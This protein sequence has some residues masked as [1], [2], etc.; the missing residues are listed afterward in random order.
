MRFASQRFDAVYCSDLGR[1]RETLAAV[2]SAPGAAHPAARFTPLLRERGAGVYEG[3]KVSVVNA[4]ARA[5]AVPPRQWRPEGAESWDDVR[6]RAS[7]FLTLLA[8]A[9]VHGERLQTTRV[10]AISHG[11]FMRELLAAASVAAGGRAGNTAVY[12]LHL[13]R[14]RSGRVCATLVRANDT[15]HLSAALTEHT[16]GGE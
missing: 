16:S 15:S 12:E 8:S 14:S 2:C 6:D 7:A 5:A 13:T 10:L 11:G 9:H 4:A 3:A 1:A